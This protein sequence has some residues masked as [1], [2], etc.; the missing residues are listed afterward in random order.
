MRNSMLYFLLLCATTYAKV[1]TLT[2]DNWDELVTNSGKNAFVKF[3]APWCGHCKKLKPDWDKLGDKYNDKSNVLIGDVDCTA[4]GKPLCETYGV[5]G[6]PTL[7]TFWKTMSDD[8][9]GGRDFETLQTFANEMKPLC[10]ITDRDNC[11]DYQNNIISTLETLS[12]V[13]LQEKFDKLHSEIKNAEDEHDA[14]LKK[15]QAQFDASSKEVE[16]LKKG[17]GFDMKLLESLLKRE[18]KDEL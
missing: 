13:Q 12:K 5:Q 7:K 3:Y 15:L 6:Y 8:Y 14:L 10:S 9:N 2:P 18:G 1:A 4:A 17:L 16:E 11:S